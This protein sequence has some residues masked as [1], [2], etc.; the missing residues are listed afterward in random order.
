MMKNGDPARIKREKET[1][2]T[3]IR[4]YC[5]RRRHQEH[6]LCP[7]CQELLDYAHKRVGACKFGAQKPTCAKCTVH[8]Y[9]PAMRARVV[10][11]MRFAGP[12]MIFYHPAR[13]FRHLLDGLKKQ[14]P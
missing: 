5:H 6:G 3:M 4:F 10:E 12:R 11:V 9:Q 13:A 7:D 2:E 1:V 14:P 8:C